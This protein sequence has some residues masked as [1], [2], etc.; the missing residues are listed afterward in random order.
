M[1]TREG[2]D[3]EASAQVCG[4]ATTMFKIFHLS[5][6]GRTLPTV[7]VFPAEL[8]HWLGIQSQVGDKRLCTARLQLLRGVEGWISAVFRGESAY[9]PVSPGMYH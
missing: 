7:V 1:D 6:G 3:R 4:V 2:E 5:P 9:K 8:I